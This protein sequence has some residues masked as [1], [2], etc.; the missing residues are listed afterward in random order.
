MFAAMLTLTCGCGDGDSNSNSIEPQQDTPTTDDSG[1][2]VG[3]DPPEW[4]A[5]IS[6]P[7]GDIQGKPDW[8]VADFYSFEYNSTAVVFVSTAFGIQVTAD[9]RMAAVVNGEVRCVDKPV[10]YSP[11]GGTESMLYFMLL[12]PHNAAD[13]GVELQYY[14]STTNKTYIMKDVFSLTDDTGTEEGEDMQVFTFYPYE[15]MMINMPQNLP[16]IPSKN[17][18]IAMFLDDVCVGV[19]IVMDEGSGQISWALEAYNQNHS[20]S[21]AIIRYYSAQ[22]R[23]IYQS[24][25]IEVFKKDVDE[26][27]LQLNY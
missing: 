11:P 6:L 21:K 1:K 26:I 12:I 22:T 2:I 5:A 10:P 16:F 24:D 8:Q 17:D 15:I 27:T 19:G 18:K 14:C 13:E 20:Q 4:V 7:D 23:T 3:V 25:P 9:D